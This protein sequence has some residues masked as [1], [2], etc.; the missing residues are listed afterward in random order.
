MTGADL[1]KLLA[2]VL[3]ATGP[4]RELDAALAVAFLPGARA[5]EADSVAGTYWCYSPS[6]GAYLLIA[7]RYTASLDAAIALMER[8][9]PGWRMGVRD[10]IGVVTAWLYSPDFKATLS[11][12][13]QGYMVEGQRGATRPLAL[14]TA[15]LKALIA[16]KAAPAR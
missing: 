13:V 4:D 1:P 10:D 15:M 9:L 8:V 5:A 11:R 6:L 12:V 3:D 14:L 2:Q 16:K 7:E